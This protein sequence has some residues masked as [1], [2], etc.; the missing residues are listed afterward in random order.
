MTKNEFMKILRSELKKLPPEETDAAVEFFEEYFDEI[1]ENGE[2]TEEEAVEE[3]GNPKRAAAQIKADYAARM[4]DGDESAQHENAT[5][6]KRLSAIW[7]II[8]GIVSAPVSVPVAGLI[9]VIAVFAICI[10]VCVLLCV[11]GLIIGCAIMALIAIAMGILAAGTAVSTTLLFFGTGMA[12]A[13][14]AAAAG[15]G[16]VRGTRALIRL[17][18]RGV[19]TANEKRRRRKAGCTE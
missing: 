19:R 13:A 14:V 10:V 15:A 1:L 3:L 11:Y 4:L 9:I 17:A 2:K 12:A 7:W 8:I 16:A 6:G 18:A 5:V